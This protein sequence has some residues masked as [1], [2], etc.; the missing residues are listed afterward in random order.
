[1]WLVILDLL[2]GDI[3]WLWDT[4]PRKKCTRCGGD[5]SL[6]KCTWPAVETEGEVK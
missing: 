2:F 5:H 3:W 6:S 4:E 1:M